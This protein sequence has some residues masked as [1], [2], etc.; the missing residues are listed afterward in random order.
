MLTMWG[1]EPPDRMALFGR[2]D[3][4]E[5]LFVLP[6]LEPCPSSSLW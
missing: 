1:W 6:V 2:D 5:L 4:D 3:G